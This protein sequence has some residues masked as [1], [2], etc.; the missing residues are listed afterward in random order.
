MANDSYS[1]VNSVPLPQR[2]ASEHASVLK[3]V[4]RHRSFASFRAIGALLLREMQTSKGRAQ[5]GYL[6]TIAEPVGGIILLTLIFSVGFRSPPIGTNFAIFYATGV[7]PFMAYLDMSNKVAGSVMYSKALLT[8]PAVTFVDALLARI[9]YNSMTHIMVAI[10]VF[11]NIYLFMDTRTD[12]QPEAIALGMLMALMLA[13]AIGTLNCFLFEAF[14]WW[15]Q[16]WGILMRPIFLLS[17]VFFIF[18]DIPQPYREWLWWNPLVHVVGQM[19][20][21]FYPSYVG[22]YISYIYVF[23]LSLSVFSIGLA[24]LIRYYR[25]LQNS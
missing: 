25:D 4:R 10:I 2:P 14:N 23:G 24:L 12:P 7:V 13:S 5:G 3:E 20:H 16:V 19:R 8:Y 18:D 15:Q 22:D 11:S 6:W 9:L 1:R 17:C 21:A